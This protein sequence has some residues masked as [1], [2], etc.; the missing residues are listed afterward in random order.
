MSPLVVTE[1][2]YL[3]YCD[4]A[5]VAMRDMVTTLGDGLANRRP[6]VP[7]GQQPLRH[8]DPLPGHDGL[9]G[10]D[11]EPRRGGPKGPRRGVHGGRARSRTSPPTPTGSGGLRRLG[12]RADA[13]AAP[14]RPPED[15][16]P[17]LTQ[18]E[19]LLHVYEELAQHR[20]QMEV[21]RDVLVAA[22]RPD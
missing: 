11:G 4:E 19:V 21:T 7:G 18:G 9:L 1:D 20:G 15:G 2:V 17:G 13:T 16:D 10:V 14:A 6:D 5:L 8:P 3:A 12:A 22:S